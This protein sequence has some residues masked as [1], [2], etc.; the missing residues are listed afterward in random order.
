MRLSKRV[1]MEQIYD[2]VKKHPCQS[3]IIKQL[4]L[5]FLDMDIKWPEFE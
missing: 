3:K 5:L 2:N 4:I 1:K